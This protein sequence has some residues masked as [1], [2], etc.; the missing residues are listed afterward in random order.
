M[1]QTYENEYVKSQQEALALFDVLGI[2]EITSKIQRKNGTRMWQVPAE[3]LF[4]TGK[5]TKLKFA[6]Y[7]SGYVRNCSDYG[8]SSYQINKKYLHTKKY[9]C[10]FTKKYKSYE[11]VK[12]ILIN[13]EEDRIIYLANYILRNYYKG[14]TLYHI[15]SYVMK[16]LPT[17]TARDY[18]VLS[19]KYDALL[20]DYLSLEKDLC[21]NGEVQVII[22]GHTYNLT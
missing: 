12:R 9:F 13:R 6:I 8:H 14:K 5:T 3:R 21:Y 18:D 7:S 16:N 22:D 10:S 2:K 19:E 1:K 17:K 11:S 15:D 20:S 4:P